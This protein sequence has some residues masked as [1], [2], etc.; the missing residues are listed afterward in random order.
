MSQ[1]APSSPPWKRI[2]AWAAKLTVGALLIWLLSR[3]VPLHDALSVLGT[4]SPGLWLL[5][6][7]MSAAV[8]AIGAYRWHLTALRSIPMKTCLAYSWIGHF[9]STVLPGAVVGDVA[10]TAALATSDTRHRTMVLP[11]SVALDRLLGL[12]SLLLVL[13]LALV[14]MGGEKK[15]LHPALVAFGTGVI[16]SGL[17]ALP[18]IMSAGLSLAK[19]LRFLPHAVVHGIDRV[20]FVLH[21]ISVRQWLL[22][23]ALSVLMHALAGSVFIV[24]AREFGMAVEAWRLGLY[25]VAVSFVIVLPVTVAGIGAR[26]QL[27]FWILGASAGA[28]TMPVA[29]SWFL[30]LTSLVHAVIGALVQLAGWVRRA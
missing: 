22:M 10:K 27:S 1:P 13:V 28:A 17:V 24:G 7:G 4:A 25:Y 26:E 9:Y 16:V 21:Q 11:V 14:A 6:T 3:R 12:V 18:Q 8:L 20:N 23:L 30:L 15:G 5:G 19:R 2:L 29:L